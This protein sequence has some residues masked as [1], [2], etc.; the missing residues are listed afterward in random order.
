MLPIYQKALL[1]YHESTIFV[2]EVKFMKPN[3]LLLEEN[4]N[5]FID[6]RWNF[7][8]SSADTKEVDYLESTV[9]YHSFFEVEIICGGRSKHIFNNETLE[10][11]RGDVYIMRYSDF[12]TYNNYKGE[13]ASIYNIKFYGTALPNEITNLFVSLPGKLMCRF[14]GAEQERFFEDI[15]LL[16]RENRRRENNEIHTNMM[17]ALFMKIMLTLLRKCLADVNELPQDSSAPFQSALTVIQCRFREKLTLA[18]IARTVGLTPNYLGS[19]FTKNLGISFSDYLRDI[20]LKYSK[21]LLRFYDYSVEQIA[22]M[23]G[24]G[25]ASHF[26]SCFKGKYGMTPKQYMIK[27]KSRENPNSG[28][29]KHRD[30][31]SHQAPSDGQ[32]N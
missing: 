26:V 11:T 17:K 13:S 21:N 4:S 10:A 12:H 2:R 29:P 24:F 20:R 30:S 6:P 8:I 18:E 3:V 16:I 22:V 23:S 5:H 19:L 9:H 31:I 28:S 27:R 14:E 7:E 1:I 15:E 25:T 32:R